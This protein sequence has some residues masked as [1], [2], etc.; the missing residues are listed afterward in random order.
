MRFVDAAMVFLLQ[1]S[2]GGDTFSYHTPTA[3]IDSFG[4]LREDPM[5][6][7]RSVLARAEAAGLLR[8]I[9]VLQRL[10]AIPAWL[11][12][13]QAGDRDLEF[14]IPGPVPAAVVEFWNSPALVCRVDAVGDFECLAHAP[15]L[16]ETDLGPGLRFAI[17]PHDGAELAIELGAGDDPPVLCVNRWNSLQAF[18]FAERFSEWVNTQVAEA[19]PAGHKEIPF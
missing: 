17:S 4:R 2:W 19:L 3:C 14:A 1:A 5:R 8:D 6:I 12:Q 18:R 16:V 13:F 11:R 9:A 7:L 10:A 15:A